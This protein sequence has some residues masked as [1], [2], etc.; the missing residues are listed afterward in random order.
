MRSCSYLYWIRAHRRSSPGIGLLHRP[1]IRRC[2]RTQRPPWAGCLNGAVERVR[3][4]VL[5][6]APSIAAVHRASRADY[7]GDPP[8]RTTV[9][10][11]CG[12]TS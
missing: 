7:Y 12:T 11:P 2:V 3:R 1:P 6:D 9:A 4:A 10:R 5:A 8:D